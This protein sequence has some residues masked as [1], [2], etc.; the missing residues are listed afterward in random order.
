MLRRGLLIF[1]TATLLAANPTRAAEDS[2]YLFTSFREPARDGLHLAYSDDALHWTDLNR[3]FLAPAVG[4]EK[5]MRD[6][7][8][9]RGPDGTFH[10]VWT[11]GWTDKGLGYASTKDLIHFSP[12]KYLRVMAHEPTT[13]NAWAPEVYFDASQRKFIVYW[14]STIP[15]RYPGDNLHPK[16]RNHRI[17]FCT[18][19]DFEGFSPT[20]VM[21]DPGYS[22]IDATIVDVPRAGVVIIFKD[23]RRPERRL[24]AAFARSALGP[25][26]DVTETFSDTL[27][28]GPSAIRVG[29]RWIVY[30]DNYNKGTYG[31]AESKDLRHWTDI[32]DRVSFP[33]GHKHGSIFTAPRSVL[34]GLK[35]F[36]AESKP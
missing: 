14:A 17:Y 26:G 16:K 15:G 35:R 31:A 33:P 29:D 6:P 18:T 8:I 21:F 1:L 34:D 27:C 7:S 10:L 24:R 3:S 12:Q 2:V 13:L 4:E 9:C 30:Y 25:F 32:S 28:E 5:L 20:K 11:A 23:E 36:V 19:G 22:V